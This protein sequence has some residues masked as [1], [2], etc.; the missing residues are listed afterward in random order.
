LSEFIDS[1]PAKRDAAQEL[2]EASAPF[3]GQGDLPALAELATTLRAVPPYE[4]R[5]EWVAAS[6]ARLMAAPVLP[7]EKRGFTWLGSMFLPL[8]Q[9]KM[10]ALP[11]LA[12]PS[13]GM[14]SSMFSRAVMAVVLI[15]GMTSVLH[16]RGGASNPIIQITEEG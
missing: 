8:T 12:L 4:P 5:L 10:P 15:V 1:L 3:T 13:L 11:A 6:R 7:L 2:L 16:N 14:P 9:L